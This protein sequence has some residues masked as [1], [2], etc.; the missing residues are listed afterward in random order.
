MS[1]KVNRLGA[2]WRPGHHARPGHYVRFL[3]VLLPL[4]LLLAGSGCKTVTKTAS[5]PFNAMHAVMPG[6]ET[7]HPPDPA[8][9]QLEE[10]RFADRLFQLTASSLDEYSSHVNTPEARL[11]AL[12]WK[13]SLGSSIVNMGTGPNPT[14]NLLDLV[15]LATLM[16]GTL[17]DVA[18]NATPPGSLDDWLSHCRVLETNAWTMAGFIINSN[19]QQVLRTAIEQ[20]RQ[21]NPAAKNIFFSRPEELATL[22]RQIELGGKDSEA[23][24]IFEKDRLDPM[25]DLDPAI[26]EITRTRLFAER[27]MFAAQ[28]TATLMRWQVELLTEQVMNQEQIVLTVQSVD[29]ISRAAESVSQT[30]ALLPGLVSSERQ[31]ILD[32]LVGEDGKLQT[33]SAQVTAQTS[34]D[35]KSVL[36][37]AFLLTAGLIVLIFACAM[38]YRR[39]GRKGV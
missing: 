33:L 25:A 1:F 16:R 28:R 7:T 17:E 3:A 38:I 8:F 6:E 27:A 35:V 22:I 10:L 34:N 23:E 37:H 12:K 21:Q 26:R 11:K 14:A 24:G 36:N 30:A 39:A 18:P 31:A 5:V 4:L 32:A 13:L 19:Q 15:T 9:V 2:A 20:W 29:R